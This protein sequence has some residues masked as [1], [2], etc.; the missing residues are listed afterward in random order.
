MCL[1]NAVSRDFR[2]HVI[3]LKKI[4]H[5]LGN[6]HVLSSKLSYCYGPKS[7][8]LTSSSWFV[9]CVS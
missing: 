5:V 4:K 6:W 3:A 8:L 1:I 2:V 7:L 9:L